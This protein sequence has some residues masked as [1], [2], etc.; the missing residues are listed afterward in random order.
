MIR[1]ARL[2]ALESPLPIM[3]PMLP[4]AQFLLPYLRRIDR[5]RIYSNFGPLAIELESRLADHF[6]VPDGAVTTVANGTLGLALALT[7]QEARPGTLC[8]IP[9]W[10]FIASPQAAAIAGLVPFFADVDPSTW[11]LD[12]YV[13][14]DII[15]KAPGEVGAVMPVV[16][17]GRPID[18]AAWDRFRSRT[19]LPVVIDA[20]A[21]FDSLRPT[22]TPAVV[23]LHATKAFGIGEG[24]FVLS[25]DRSLI[26]SARTR[27][28]FGFERTREAIV[29]SINAKL[30]EYHAAVGHAALDEWG[31]ARADW[32]AVAG[33]YRERLAGCEHTRLQ[34]GFGESWVSSVCVFQADGPNAGELD[35]TLENAGIETRRWWGEGAHTH[36]STR[37]LPR[38]AL[39]VTEQLARSTIAVPLFRDMRAAEIDRVTDGFL[40]S[41]GVN[42]Q[43][44]RSR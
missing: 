44:L 18:F 5:A 13:V 4:P 10:T 24:G 15:A 40:S 28:N 2:E 6:G 11:A 39:P 43:L 32:L 42:A 20:A 17:F 37:H 27:A 41:S 23:S 35:A 16:P 14:S 26:R 9:A 7:A 30:S 21:G 38:T 19:G 3:R 31:I 12:P 22:A 29:P 25:T 36:R 34:E 8:V 33:A 1:I